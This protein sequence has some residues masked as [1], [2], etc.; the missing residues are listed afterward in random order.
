MASFRFGDVSWYNRA[1]QFA[2]LTHVR[3]ANALQ[4]PRRVTENALSRS[5]YYLEIDIARAGSTFREIV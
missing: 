2:S 4:I 5:H 3:I 1:G